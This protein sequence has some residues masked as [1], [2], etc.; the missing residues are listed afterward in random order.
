MNLN[1]NNVGNWYRSSLGRI[2]LLLI[3]IVIVTLTVAYTPYLNIVISPSTRFL[4][5]FLVWYILF[6]P[7]ANLLISFCM[8]LLFTA[9]VTT[10]LDLDFLSES[11]GGIIYLLLV[12][13]LINY[14]TSFFQKERKR[15]E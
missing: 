9:V 10:L 12:L 2:V 4:I 6:S 15:L 8:I 3:V 7:S 11:F 14:V 13:I 5:V 1:K